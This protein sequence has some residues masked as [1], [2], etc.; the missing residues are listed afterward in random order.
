M[1]TFL[2]FAGILGVPAVCH[3]HSGTVFR[4]ATSILPLL[5]PFL[6]AAMF[7][8]RR[9]IQQFFAAILRKTTKRN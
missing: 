3:A 1:L 8:C 7:A 2:V 6:S 4:A 5:L 9:R